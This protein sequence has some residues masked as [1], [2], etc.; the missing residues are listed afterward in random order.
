MFARRASLAASL[1]A[2]A[3]LVSTAAQA[4]PTTWTIDP[5]HSNV[6]FTIRHFFSKV[7][8]S[9]TKFS[10]S[11]VYDPANPGASSA[12]AEIDA[13]SINTSNDRR[14]GHLRSPDFFDV[15][16]YPT[17]TFESTKVTADGSK[18]KIEGNLT[19]HG[20]TKPVTLEG[21]FLGA[22]PAMGGQRAGFEA[23][24]KV[25]RKD[26][27]IIW[28]KVVDQGTMLGDDVE[29]RLAIEGA[30]EPAGGG[31]KAEAGSKGD[32]KKTE[33]NAK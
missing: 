14:D 25:D 6:T 7:T 16:K 27:G 11:V 18:L 22:G 30:T 9:F 1:F 29:I 12:K 31:K 17:L 21:E 15:A 4:A 28:N 26:F 10:G 32:E 23:S 5:N 19:M 33:A 13:A 24:T 20:V 3:L 2:A 8:G